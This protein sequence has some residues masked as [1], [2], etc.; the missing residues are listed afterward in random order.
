MPPE[1]SSVCPKGYFRNT[2][3]LFPC[4]ALS[5]HPPFALKTIASAYRAC[6]PGVA[7]A[8]VSPEEGVTISVPSGVKARDPVLRPMTVAH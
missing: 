4:D 1:A 3:V 8:P 2:T 6:N 7:Y 5:G